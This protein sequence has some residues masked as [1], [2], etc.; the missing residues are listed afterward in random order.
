MPKYSGGNAN[1]MYLPRWKYIS[2]QMIT[3][4]AASQALTIPAGTQI[5]EIRARGGAIYWNINAGAAA[6]SPGYIPQDSGEI[7]GPLHDVEYGGSI[8]VYGAVGAFAHVM[9]F[10][11]W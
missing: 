11:E 1:F 4:N 8:N 10:K 7:I 9:Y 3:A 5:V 6:T 2:G